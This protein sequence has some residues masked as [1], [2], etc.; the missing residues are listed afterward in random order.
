MLPRGAVHDRQIRLAFVQFCFQHGSGS[1]SGMR[2]TIG[3]PHKWPTCA[4][5]TRTL[6]PHIMA[7]T[8]ATSTFRLISRLNIIVPLFEYLSVPR[9]PFRRVVAKS[10]TLATVSGRLHQG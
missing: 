7:T 6:Q 9:A 4:G 10:S 3:M 8:K 1:G 5:S 2:A